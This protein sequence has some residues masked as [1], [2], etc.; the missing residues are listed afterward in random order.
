MKNNNLSIF[1]HWG[2]KTA[3]TQVTFEY[4]IALCINPSSK[5]KGE[6]PLFLCSN[7]ITKTKEGMSDSKM[8]CLVADIDHYDI[9]IKSIEHKLKQAGCDY[10]V[11]STSS[12]MK[13]ID[14]EKATKRW[15][16]VLKLD[17]SI[18]KNHWRQLQKGLVNVFNGDKA[19]IRPTQ[20]SYVPIK[21]SDTSHY[22]YAFK[23]KL[24]G[25]KPSDRFHSDLLMHAEIYDRDEI[26][27]VSKRSAQGNQS[28]VFTGY[29]EPNQK[30]SQIDAYNHHTNIHFLLE[31]AGYKK[32]GSKYVH[33]NSTSGMAGI[34]VFNNGTGYYSHHSSD[35]LYCGDDGKA[36]DAF[37]VFKW[38]EHGGDH[39]AAS[40]AAGDMFLVTSIKN[41]NAANKLTI[42]EWNKRAVHIQNRQAR[43]VA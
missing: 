30:V 1:N 2:D 18:N 17:S 40:N 35:P 11:Y 4:L 3:K 5:Q 9:D 13:A 38:L 16:I 24:G 21:N 33:P 39:Y 25:L 31:Q 14:N 7:A 12:S 22:E 29:A 34:T 42:N 15:R 26:E 41:P 20:L 36:F 23:T 8:N 28:C 6:A 27:K 10:V 37:S 19:M 43:G 32:K